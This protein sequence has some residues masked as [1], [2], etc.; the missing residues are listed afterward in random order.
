MAPLIADMVL[1][2]KDSGVI[3]SDKVQYF[4]GWKPDF[5][6]PALKTVNNVTYLQ[7][8]GRME[9]VCPVTLM[10]TDE[11]PR[12]NIAKMYATIRAARNR[13]WMTFRD[14]FGDTYDVRIKNV[15]VPERAPNSPYVPVFFLDCDLLM[16]GFE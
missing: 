10:F 14:R 2:R 11:F 16:K 1:T 15:P 13:V 3:L 7:K 4:G 12:S 9:W 6:D 5:P 8:R